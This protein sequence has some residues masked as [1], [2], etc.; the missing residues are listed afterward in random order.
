MLEPPH[1]PAP[2]LS[3]ESAVGSTEQSPLSLPPQTATVDQDE[4]ILSDAREY[5]SLP[6][7]DA[8]T[9]SQARRAQ[10]DRH[11]TL[12]SNRGNDPPQTEPPPPQPP[13]RTST[14]HDPDAK[15]PP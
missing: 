10:I 5:S 15:P 11:E 2:S 7:Q 6:S 13:A 8:L 9:A 1:T 12:P 4:L 14:P 3:F